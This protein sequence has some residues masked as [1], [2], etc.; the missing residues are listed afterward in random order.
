MRKYKL[1]SIVIGFLLFF[2]VILSLNTLNKDFQPKITYLKDPELLPSSAESN[3]QIINEIFNNKA[4]SYEDDGFFPQ[5]YEHSLQATYYGLFILNTIGKIETVNKSKIAGYIMSNYNSSLGIFMDDYAS[6]Y[7]GT[8]FSYIYYPLSTV[9]EVN[10]YALLS[11]SLLGT[12]I[13]LSEDDNS[14]TVYSWFNQINCK[15]CLRNILKPLYFMS[16]NNPNIF[17]IFNNRKW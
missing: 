15:Q 12:S 1:L 2:G 7:M 4:N 9:L 3:Y 14:Q 5:L 6:R 10:C 11:L 8:D 16:F 13:G 17:N